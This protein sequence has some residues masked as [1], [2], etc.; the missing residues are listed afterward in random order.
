MSNGYKDY[1]QDLLVTLLAKMHEVGDLYEG[2]QKAFVP[3][4]IGELCDVLDSYVEDF[5]V[6]QIKEKFGSL[7]IYKGWK[8]REYTEEEFKDIDDITTEI[9]S[10]IDKYRKISYR[11]C[12]KCGGNATF[13]SDGWVIPWCDSC[14]DRK[15]GVFGIIEDD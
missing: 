3:D 10:I 7:T 6:Y 14:R 11:T 8:D 1:K 12:V 4:M 13:L 15:M 9:N 2:W 5:E